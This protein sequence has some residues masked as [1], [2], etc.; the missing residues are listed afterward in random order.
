MY[1]EQYSRPDDH[2]DDPSWR[3]S[4]KVVSLDLLMQIL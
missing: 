3:N 1:T 2:I 4:Q